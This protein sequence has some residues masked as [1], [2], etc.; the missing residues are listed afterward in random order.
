[1]ELDTLSFNSI[2]NGMFVDLFSCAL[3]ICS[4]MFYYKTFR[5]LIYCLESSFLFRILQ[6]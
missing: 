3:F 5:V 2:S 4:I 6:L 1:M